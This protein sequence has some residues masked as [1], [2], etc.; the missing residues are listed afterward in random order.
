MN[1]ATNMLRKSFAEQCR[2]WRGTRSQAK[3]AKVLKVSLSS[4]RN[5]EQGRVVPDYKSLIL[6]AMA[7]KPDLS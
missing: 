6:E 7:N 4:I 5:W 2:E 3:A 1:T